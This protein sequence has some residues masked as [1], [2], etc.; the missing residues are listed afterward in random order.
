MLWAYSLEALL[1]S[2]KTNLPNNS[3]N[4]KQRISNSSS[5]QYFSV[6]TIKDKTL[7][8][9]MKRKGLDS[10]FNAWEVVHSVNANNEK[11]RTSSRRGFGFIQKNDWFKDHKVSI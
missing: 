6:G 7:V 1:P 4:A 3:T 11:G 5:V 9:S 8:V 10:Y 2:F